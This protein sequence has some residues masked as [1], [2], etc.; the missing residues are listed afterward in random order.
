M[1]L[2]RLYIIIIIL[3]VLTTFTGIA[4]EI[5][6]SI[7]YR[8]TDFFSY[9]LAGRMIIHGQDPYDSSAW[10][11]GHQLFGATWI[12]DPEFLYPLPLAFIFAPLGLLTLYSAYVV[13]VVV[14]EVTISISVWLLLKNTGKLKIQNILPVIAGVVLFRP[15]IITLYGGQL[16]GFLLLVLASVVYLWRREKWWQGC[17]LMAFLILKPNLGF[18][19]IGLLSLWLVLEKRA[20]LLFWVAG[21]VLGLA[22]TGL[23]YNSHWCTDYL[24][25]GN[26]KLSLTFGYSPTIWGM[27]SYLSGSKMVPTIIIG[28]I[29]ALAIIGGYFFFLLRNPS[30][31]T[32]AEVISMVTTITLLVTPYTWPYDQLLLVVP[33]LFLVNMM[34]EMKFP[35]LISATF[36]IIIDILTLGLLAISGIIKME[37]FNGLIPL[38]IFGISLF[39]L[40]QKWRVPLKSPAYKQ[41][42]D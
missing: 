25:I 26:S 29:L 20:R 10:I 21:S 13:W 37:I 40:N 6:D 28:G 15:T 2:K 17:I 31:S 22:A 30:K 19:I 39:I 18:P 4:I 33:V 7:E 16:S 9:W 23:L 14:L 38:L 5:V 27:L 11:A 34:I 1:K 41:A 8:N 42:G 3:V 24:A 36:W 32:P 35:Y 12:S